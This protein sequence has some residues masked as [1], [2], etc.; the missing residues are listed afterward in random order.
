MYEKLKSPT[1]ANLS[2][3][4]PCELDN[5]AVYLGSWAKDGMREGKGVQLWKDGSKYEGYWK[6]D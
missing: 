3:K 4:G 1:N 6:K 5:G 2:Q